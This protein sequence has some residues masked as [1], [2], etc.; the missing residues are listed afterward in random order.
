MADRNP[1]LQ[2]LPPPSPESLVD[3][4]ANSASLRLVNVETT[5]RSPSHSA[6]SRIDEIHNRMLTFEHLR[7]PTSSPAPQN[8]TL[9]DFEFQELDRA[10]VRS[11]L[12]W[13][14]AHRQE[15]I[16]A[17]GSQYVKDKQ[18]ENLRYQSFRFILA[19]GAKHGH[20]PELQDQHLNRG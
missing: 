19:A 7:M 15:M 5:Y 13:Q 17:E 2:F 8:R 12:D 18:L 10:R 1:N 20:M 16:T 9:T 3:T 11:E 6:V 4:N 14:R